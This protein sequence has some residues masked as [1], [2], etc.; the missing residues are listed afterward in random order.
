MGES[1]R[2]V[3]VYCDASQL[4][5]D[6]PIPVLRVLRQTNNPGMAKNVERNVKA[7]YPECDII[8]NSNWEDLKKTRFMHELTNHAF[9]RVDAGELEER[10][11]VETLPLE[12][13][14]IIAVS[15]YDK[16]FLTREDLRA[17]CIRHDT[18]FVDTKKP[19]GEF[20]D[21]SRFIKINEKEYRRSTPVSDRLASKII[22]TKAERGAEF[23]G[24]TYPVDQIEVKDVSGAGDSFFAG[25]VVRYAETR[26]IISSIRFANLCAA[27]VVQHRGVTVI[28]RPA[29]E[30]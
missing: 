23:Q 24:V 12:D 3:F 28:S 4:A 18:V 16:G 7:I 21:R 22:M 30:T 5:P 2:D 15:D 14:D 1:C 10:V 19:V 11:D 6:V 27:Q 20:L 13:Y 25:L 29:T 17:I 26:D 8:T 9:V